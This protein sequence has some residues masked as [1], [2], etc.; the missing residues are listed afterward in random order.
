MARYVMV[1]LNGATP[2][3]DAEAL[4]R[5]YEDV[6]LADL[7]ATPGVVS[8]RRFKTVRGH[9][10]GGELWPYVALIEIET[11]DIEAFQAELQR[12][13][14]PVHPDLDRARSAHLIAEQTAPSST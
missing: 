14:R 10:P 4:E 12:R 8:A 6:H 13:G 9:A 2:G 3:G 1:A 11:D 7:R 5:W